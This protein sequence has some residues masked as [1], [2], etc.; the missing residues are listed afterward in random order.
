[1]PPFVKRRVTK[2]EDT[3]TTRRR[4]WTLTL[5]CGHTTQR[6]TGAPPRVQAANC[7]R[8]AVLVKKPKP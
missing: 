5:E 8:C 2:I 7:A 3:S 1:M 6:Q 4:V